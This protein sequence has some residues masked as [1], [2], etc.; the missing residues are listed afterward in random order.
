MTLD[1]GAHLLLACSSNWYEE[2]PAQAYILGTA[3]WSFGTHSL[4]KIFD[5][6]KSQTQMPTGAEHISRMTEGSKVQT[7]RNCKEHFLRGDHC[8]L[9]PVVGCG[10]V[11]LTR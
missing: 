9:Q 2:N 6:Q 10:K 5:H 8:Q 1:F 4:E 3:A 11:Y 7:L